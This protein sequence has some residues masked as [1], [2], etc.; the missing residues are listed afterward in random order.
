MIHD[1]QVAN[2]INVLVRP[3]EELSALIPQFIVL[4]LDGSIVGC[5]GYKLWDN[6]AEIISW[7]VHTDY[8]GQNWGD[9]LIKAC[10]QLAREREVDL[11]F[12]LTTWRGRHFLERQGWIVVGINYLTKKVITD[13]AHCP[14]N[15][16]LEGQ[17]LCD[18]IALILP[19][20]KTPS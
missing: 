14:K 16:I 20:Q 12:T 6:Q 15:Q 18:E 2:S 13:C 5:C 11:I 10:V 1:L 3:L 9:K 4:E 8:Q 7:I 19:Q 17:Y